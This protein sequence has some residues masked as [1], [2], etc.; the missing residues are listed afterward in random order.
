MIAGDDVAGTYTSST[1]ISSI[2]ARTCRFR[3]FLLS[4]QGEIVKVY[5]DPI[6]AARLVEDVRRIEVSAAERLARAVPFPGTFHSSPGERNYFQYGLE[7]S[8]QG[9]DA[10]ALIA[11]ER[12]A[13]ADPSAITFYNLGTLYMKGGQPREAKAA[14]ERALELQPDYA[15]AGNSLGALLAQSGDGPGR[16]RALPR[17]LEGRSPT[18]PMRSTTW[19]SRCSRR[20]SRR[21]PTT[22]TKGPEAPTRL[23]GGAQQPRHLLRPPG[24]PRS[25]AEVI[26]QAVEQA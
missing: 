2:A 20:A 26:P 13:K 11:F 18:S 1:A 21:R 14:F 7:L 23:P 6:A 16:H 12:V 15:D 22:S 8:E 19:A 17:G 5:R 9:F 25:R 24:G 3:P 4:A 10:P